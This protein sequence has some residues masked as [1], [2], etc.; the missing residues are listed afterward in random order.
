MGTDARPLYGA[1]P[2]RPMEP[3]RVAK[4]AETFGRIGWRP[5]VSLPEGLERTVAWYRAELERSPATRSA[6]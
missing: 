5:Q 3:I 6:I 1:L 2:D 4:T